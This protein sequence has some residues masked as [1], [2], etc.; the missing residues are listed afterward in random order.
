MEEVE[1]DDGE[2]RRRLLQRLN[3]SKQGTIS[4]FLTNGNYFGASSTNG[5]GGGDTRDGMDGR[6]TGRRWRKA[7]VTT[8]RISKPMGFKKTKAPANIKRKRGAKS[9]T[10]KETGLERSD[11][12][13]STLLGFIRWEARPEEVGN[14]PG[15]SRKDTNTH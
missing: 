1:K 14:S 6:K 8:D 3:T 4:H 11:S 12:S 2:D 13:Q 5:N 15:S 9:K 10:G 7:C